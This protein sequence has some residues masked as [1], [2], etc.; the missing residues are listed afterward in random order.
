MA[1]RSNSDEQAG[2]TVTIPIGI[3]RGGSVEAVPYDAT[4]LADAAAK[5]PQGV[6]TVGRTYQRD[7]ALLLDKHFDRLERSAQLEGMA[8][9]LDRPAIRKALRTLI[10]QSGY[11]DSRF[12]I[13]VPRDHPDQP[14]ISLEP[15][16]PVP[17]E[18]VENGARVVTVQM[19]RHNPA[20]KTTGWITER[21]A[22]TDRFAPGI[23]EGILTSADGALLEGTNSNFYAVQG[24]VLRTADDNSVLSGI[25]RGILLAVAPDILPLQFSP[26]HVADI[27]TLSEALLTSS[28]RGVVPI[29]EIDGRLIADGRPGPF[30]TRLRQAYDT[31]SK[32]HLEPI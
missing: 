12:R 22:A 31:W 23:Y 4:S 29:V 24:G 20:A 2:T 3:V 5:E 14:I 26:V 7:H 9:Q 15:F 25:V 28:G 17:S 1:Q 13:T 16:K 32:A 30:T 18:I 10:D 21:K 6:Y 8:I 27:P 19:A 11:A